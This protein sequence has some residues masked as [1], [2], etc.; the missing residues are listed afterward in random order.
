MTEIYRL[1]Q[2]NIACCYSQINQV[3]AGLEALKFAMLAGFEDYRMIRS[4]ES[5]KQLRQ[6]EMFEK[7]MS[8]ARSRRGCAV[9]MPSRGVARSLCF[10]GPR[11][12]SDRRRD[13]GETDVRPLTRVIASLAARSST[14]RS[15]M[16]AP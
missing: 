9:V 11:R 15:S 6:N 4:D 5:L 3:D 7:L 14:S 2:Y 12:T 8:K 1:A 10:A 16:S 13:R